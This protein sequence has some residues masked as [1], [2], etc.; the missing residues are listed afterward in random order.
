MLRPVTGAWPEHMTGA[1]LILLYF[2]GKP[3]PIKVIFSG[4]GKTKKGFLCATLCDMKNKS[5]VQFGL[6]SLFPLSVNHSHYFLLE[7]SKNNWWSLI[8][9]VLTNQSPVSKS[10]WSIHAKKFWWSPNLSQT[11]TDA[12]N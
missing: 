2:R 5:R 1:F 7:T 4:W 12:K 8:V 3:R 10:V 11:L 6:L 9:K